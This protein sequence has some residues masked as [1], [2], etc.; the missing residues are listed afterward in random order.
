MVSDR[1][2]DYCIGKR[3][4][5]A[6]HELVCSGGM[7]RFERFGRVVSRWGG[8]L[9]F[10]AFADTPRSFFRTQFD[11]LGIAEAARH[12]WDITMVPGAGF[13][14]ATI[15]RLRLLQNPVFGLRVQ[16]ILNSPSLARK[17][18]AV[19][20]SF[21]PDVVIFNNRHWSKNDQRAL[22]TTRQAVVEGAVDTDRL[23]P[24]RRNLFREKTV[25][26]GGLANKNPGPLLEALKRL[27]ERCVP[28][29]FGDPRAARCMGGEL[30]RNGRLEFAGLLQEN[31][32][33]KYYSGLDCVVHTETFAGWSNLA[34]EALACGVPLICT[35]HGTLA[36]AE[37]EKTA[38]IVEP[39]AAAIASALKRMCGDIPL[40]Q[41]LA[42]RGREKIASFTWERY[43]RDLLATCNE[44][45]RTGACSRNT[46]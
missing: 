34:A 40:A 22:G 29:L 14:S 36:F 17:F 30:L 23:A 46:R 21:R 38:L 1:P 19:S 10:I 33:C 13:P 12:S 18:L 15:R 43:T 32:L 9:C 11:I 37:H 31:E 5:V 44:F 27:P 4:A 41:A 8:T 20:R 3:I 16:H 26:I 7:L 42:R 24:G 2:V 28:R 39:H 35:P 6:C 25:I 45:N